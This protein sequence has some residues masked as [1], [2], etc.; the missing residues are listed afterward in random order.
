MTNSPAVQ[1]AAAYLRALEARAPIAEITALL[2]DDFVVEVL[3]N[4]L[5][6]KGSR[7]TQGEAAVDMERGRALLTEEHYAVTSSFGDATRAVL[8]V[9]WTGALAIELGKLPTGTPLRARC[10]MHFELRDG[11]LAAQRNYDCFDP[12]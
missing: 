6:P 7:R 9:T 5:A 8:E 10:S 3:P 2:H 4:T 1:L 11:K 12:F